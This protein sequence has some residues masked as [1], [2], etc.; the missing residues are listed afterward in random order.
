MGRPRR[1]S[2]GVVSRCPTLGPVRAFTLL[3]LIIAVVYGLSRIGDLPRG[4]SVVVSVYDGDTIKLSDGRKIRYIG[5]DAPETGGYRPAEYYGEEAKTLNSSLVLG[6]HV[7]IVTD[8]ESTDAYGRTL[9]YVFVDDLFVNEEMIRAGAALAR[10]YP[11]NVTH[12]DLFCDAMNEARVEERGMWAD[13]DAWMVPQ[14]EADAHIG[15]SKTVV[16]RVMASEMTSSGVFL[17]FGPDYTTDFTV[18]I[19]TDSLDAFHGGG[20]DNPVQT[21]R[22]ETIEVI[23]TITDKNGPSIRV[24]SPCQIYIRP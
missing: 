19:P 16:G 18:F 3:I 5:L 7:T 12:Q 24:T 4:E 13:I 10:P 11:P 15:L 22:G 23:G 6:K 8:V 2:K 9:A 14:N 17:N 21:Y 20:V 1:T